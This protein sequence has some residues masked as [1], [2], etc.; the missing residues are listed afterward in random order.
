MFNRN[1][2]RRLLGDHLGIDETASDE[3]LMR[4]YR[5]GHERAFN[6]LFRR[7]SGRVYGYLA[8]RLAN[9]S[10]VD[11]VFQTVFMKLHRS[12]DHYDP[13]FPFQAWLFSIARSSLI[14]HLRAQ[15][16]KDENP[17]QGPGE[18][19][20]AAAAIDLSVLPQAQRRA[21]E[22]RYDEDLTFDEIA[23]KLQTSP[24]NVRQLVSRGIKALRI[25]M[26]VKK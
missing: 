2:S 15:K 1:R 23:E 14:D 10:Q 22:L 6:L 4:V 7:H 17:L 16:A 19:P 11:D 9:R 18:E 12:R 8:R 3:E 21:L 26:G 20:V 25:M 24:S 5:Q 13:S